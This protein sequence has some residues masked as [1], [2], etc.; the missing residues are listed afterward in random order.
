[1]ENNLDYQL[2]PHTYA[3]CLNNQCTQSTQCLRYLVAQNSTTQ[4]NTFTIINP[5]CIPE[6]TATCTFFK[7][8]Q[9]VR[10]AWGIKHLLDG[11][12]YK[13]GSS[14][15]RKLISHFGKTT[16]YRI[17]RME[18]GLFPED[19]DFIRQLFRGNGI[20]KEPEFEKY[21]DEYYFG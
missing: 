1:M 16:Y 11:V 19:Q 20:A 13:D 12:P 2:V 9:K 4:N 7:S 15:R 8:I 3:H 21:T 6:D 14:M 18:R 10:L 5:K 17:Y